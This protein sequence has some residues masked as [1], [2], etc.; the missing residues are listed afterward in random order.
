MALLT[1][2]TNATTTL[3]A[4]LY[5]RNPPSVADVATFS[6]NVKNDQINGRPIVPG[7]FRF[8]QLVIPNRGVLQLVPGDY[9]AYDSQ[10]W[11]ILVSANSIANG[12]WTH[13]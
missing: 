11:P 4:L 5:T 13:S 6:A 9:V 7:A 2:G 8:G 3:S 1:L 10:G 12:L